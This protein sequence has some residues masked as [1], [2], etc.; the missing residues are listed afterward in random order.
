MTERRPE[1]GDV[2]RLVGL[3]PSGLVNRVIQCGGIPDSGPG[4][5]SVP[6]A[7]Q[8]AA[9]PPER[10]NT[11]EALEGRRAWNKAHH[12]IRI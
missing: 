3:V 10:I 1:L 6:R 7:L 4:T 2:A 9:K 5:Y 11:Q 8:A 12:K